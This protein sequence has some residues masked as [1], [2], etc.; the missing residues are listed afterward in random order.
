MLFTHISLCSCLLLAPLQ[1][2]WV[3]PSAAR[4]SSWSLVWGQLLLEGVT[5]TAEGS[6]GGGADAGGG[7]G[8]SGLD[9]LLEQPG[10]LTPLTDGVYVGSVLTGEQLALPPQTPYLPPHLS[11]LVLRQQ[12]GMAAAAVQV[13]RAAQPAAVSWS[14]P[15]TLFRLRN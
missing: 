13:A 6:S 8:R 1:L 3:G 10:S 12:Q 15:R 5:L 14:R 11:S 4:V 9:V 2:S 7:G